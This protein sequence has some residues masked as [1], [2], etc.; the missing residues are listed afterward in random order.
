MIKTEII[1]INGKTFKKTY[2]D[3]N[4]YIKKLESNE[5]YSDAIDIIDSNYKYIETDKEVLKPDEDIR[6]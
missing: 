5:E 3:N 2:S 6:N 4:K 1:E